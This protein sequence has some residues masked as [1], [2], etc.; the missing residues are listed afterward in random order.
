MVY[1]SCTAVFLWTK[2][3]IFYKIFCMALYFWVRSCTCIS[4]KLPESLWWRTWGD[5]DCYMQRHFY[6]SNIL[7]FTSYKHRY[8]ISDKA[9]RREDF[10]LTYFL[11]FFLSVK[12]ILCYL[13]VLHSLDQCTQSLSAG[14]TVFFIFAQNLSKVLWN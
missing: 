2:N 8:K 13:F 9:K 4:V 7:Y 12:A 1:I 14:V 3:S 10:F 5:N 11:P 6:K